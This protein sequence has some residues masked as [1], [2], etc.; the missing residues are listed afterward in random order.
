MDNFF[1]QGR[2]EK[3]MK[4]TLTDLGIACA[5]GR[6]KDEVAIISGRGSRK[7]YRKFGYEKVGPYM[8]KKLI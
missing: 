2:F 5:L 6:G 4:F 1:L 3:A 8:I 7:Y